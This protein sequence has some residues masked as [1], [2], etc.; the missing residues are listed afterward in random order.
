MA[1]GMLAVRVKKFIE[2]GQEGNMDLSKKNEL[3]SI[4]MSK[5]ECFNCHKK[6][7]LQENADL[8]GV[9]EEDLMVKNGNGECKTTESSSQAL[10]AQDGLGGYDWSNDFEVEPV[11]LLLCMAIPL[12]SSSSSWISGDEESTLANNRFTKANEYSCCFLLQITGTQPSDALGGWVGGC[13]EIFWGGLGLSFFISWIRCGFNR[14]DV[15][16]EDWTSD[17]EEDMC[18]VNTVSYVKPN[19]TQAVRS[20]ADKSVSTSQKTKG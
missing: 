16:I 17:D 18:H 13:G 9:K 15:I 7:T 3:F 6:G 10:V 4:D 12:S 11:K 8:P 20:Q 5:I 19:V 2:E 14:D 1:G